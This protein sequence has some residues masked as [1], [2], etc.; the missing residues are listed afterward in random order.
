MPGRSPG[1]GH[2]RLYV[3]DGDQT[4]L[5]PFNTNVFYSIV[6]T[7]QADRATYSCRHLVRHDHARRLTMGKRLCA[8][9]GARDDGRCEGDALKLRTGG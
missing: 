5:E 6:S 2:F 3:E 9:A 7:K 1:S 8:D 4:V